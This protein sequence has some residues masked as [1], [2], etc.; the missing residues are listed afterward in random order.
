MDILSDILA[1]SHV[2]SSVLSEIDCRGEW[3]I[4]MLDR[5][6]VVS[7]R[8][9][10]VPFHYVL[11]G[12]GYLQDRE[13]CTPLEAGDLIVAPS[14]PAHSLVANPRLQAI[15][16]TDIIS[17]NGIEI[18]DGSTFS[19]PLQFVAGDGDSSARLLSGVL[20][21]EGHAAGILMSQL[22]KLLTLKLGQDTLDGQFAT[23]LLFIRQ[24]QK[25]TRPGYVALAE[26]LTDLMFIQIIRACVEAAGLKTGL[27]AALANRNI[28]I[29]LEAVHNSPSA[30]WSV[31]SLAKHSGLSRTVFAEKFR[32]L[33]GVTPIQY[34]LKW[35]MIIAENMLLRTEAP[36]GQ[37]QIRAGFAS[38]FA[39]ARAFKLE[40]GMSPREYRKAHRSG[41]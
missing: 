2:R 26:R 9:H 30:G 36:I 24:E 12:Q 29:A 35:R 8:I 7:S 11:E 37:I 21:I 3:A 15:K 4:D 22:P 23:A 16:I 13:N 14:W 28:S 33:V 10:A 5:S 31:A 6:V 27:L 17:S 32:A 39:F 1:M 41:G 20:T 25:L 19:K 38:S 18:W 34:L 40:F